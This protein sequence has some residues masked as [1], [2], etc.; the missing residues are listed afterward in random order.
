[1]MDLRDSSVS[2][3]EYYVDGYPYNTPCRPWESSIN[4]AAALKYVGAQ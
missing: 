1:M 2:W 4:I 3:V